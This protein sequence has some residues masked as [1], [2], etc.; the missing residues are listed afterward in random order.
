MSNV[1]AYGNGCSSHSDCFCCPEMDCISNDVFTGSNPISR[2]ALIPQTTYRKFNNKSQCKY[3][4]SK[5]ISLYGS[6]HGVSRYWCK[7]CKRK[8]KEDDT[9]YHMKVAREIVFLSLLLD[10][11]GKTLNQIKEC[12]SD[13][14]GYSPSN[15]TIFRWIR[16]NQNGTLP[17]AAAGSILN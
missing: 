11:Q 16:N 1:L 4:G 14:F 8:Y 13:K 17:A 6:Y 2:N 7:V 9:L 12:I 10:A 15:S 5:F 3:C